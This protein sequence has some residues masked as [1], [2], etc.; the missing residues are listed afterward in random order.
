[1]PNETPQHRPAP[2][3]PDAG[4]AGPD[5]SSRRPFRNRPPPRLPLQCAS[6]NSGSPH[7]RLRRNLPAALQALPIRPVYVPHQ[8]DI[9]PAVRTPAQQHRT[10]PGSINAAAYQNIPLHF[11]YSPFPNSIDRASP[12]GPIVMRYDA[13][14]SFSLALSDTS[15]DWLRSCEGPFHIG[16]VRPPCA[17]PAANQPPPRPLKRKRPRYKTGAV[18]CGCLYAL[19]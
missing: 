18:P 1:M 10:Q 6:A 3:P 19:R 11:S 7:Q 16:A 17:P 13:M 14:Q 5:R 2:A 12:A 4:P 8:S 15:G 9:P